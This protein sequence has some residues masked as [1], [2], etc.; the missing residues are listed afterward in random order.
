MHAA[1]QSARGRPDA[2]PCQ[3]RSI[4]GFG[5]RQGLVEPVADESLGVS[6]QTPPDHVARESIDSS[7]GRPVYPQQP[8]GSSRSVREYQDWVVASRAPSG[9]SPVS[10]Q[11]WPPTPPAVIGGPLNEQI[12][13]VRRIGHPRLTDLG[14]VDQESS[15]RSS[16]DRRH[17]M[18][19]P[20]HR[21]QPRKARRGDQYHRRVFGDDCV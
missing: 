7:G 8:L 13:A 6:V 4:A 20:Y 21:V 14:A 12:S 1:Q 11:P 9:G 18:A 19:Q 16:T 5:R 2:G 15:P 17:H 3:R 10:L